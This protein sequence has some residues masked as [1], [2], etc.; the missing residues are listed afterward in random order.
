MSYEPGKGGPGH[1]PR[2]LQ[3]GENPT[4]RSPR[5]APSTRLRF[6]WGDA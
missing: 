5:Q 4:P 1:L 3:Q 2:Q 6:Q